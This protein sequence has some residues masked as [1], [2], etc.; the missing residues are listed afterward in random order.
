[1]RDFLS[2]QKIAL[3]V[4]LIFGV[5]LTSQVIIHRQSL[6][7]VVSDISAYRYTT[8]T[9]LPQPTQQP[10]PTPLERVP[11]EQN[12]EVITKPVETEPKVIYT[13]PDDALPWGVAQKVDDVTYSIKVGYDENMATPSEVLDALNQYRSTKGV[14]SLVWDDSLAQYAQG[15][16]NTFESIGGTDK[17][18]GFNNFLENEDGFNQLRYNRVG[19]NSFYGGPLTGTHLIEWV[20]T[21]S[22]GHDS[23]QLDSGWTHVGIGVSASSV[24]L[25]FASG[26]F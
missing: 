7:N 1:M 4:G 8:Q 10:Y 22:P 15:R 26:K 9:I 23:N 24:N 2:P 11:L 5:I 13:E 12:A 20:F 18:A 19:E 14:S 21:Q 25:I 6:E 16:A 3:A 17:H